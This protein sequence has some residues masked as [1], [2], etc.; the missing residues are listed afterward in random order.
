CRSPSCWSSGACERW[1]AGASSRYEDAARLRLNRWRQFDLVLLLAAGTLVAYGVAVID[2][3][4]CGPPCARLLPPTSWAIRQGEYALAGLALL[5]AVTLID[6]RVYRAL[7]YPLFACGL[8]CLV[9]V[10]LVGRGN[11]EYGA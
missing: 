11:E 1:P 4:T 3:A 9:L 10:L 5:L 6:Y 2:S 7:A 8:L